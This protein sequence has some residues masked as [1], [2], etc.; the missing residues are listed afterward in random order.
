[1]CRTTSGLLKVSSVSSPLKP[2]AWVASGR[3]WNA[4]KFSTWTQ[5][6]QDV[7]KPQGEPAE[8]RRL[9]ASPTSAQVFG[10]TSGSRP[11]ERN[12]SLLRSEERRV[13][14]EWRSGG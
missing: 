13:G 1:M 2:L 3:L 10:G 14:K 11:A 5:E 6:G 8:R 7:V 12:I 4:E 9:A